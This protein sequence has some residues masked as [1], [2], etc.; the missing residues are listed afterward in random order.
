MQGRTSIAIA[1]RLSTI[2]SCDQIFVIDQG[3]II[4]KGNHDKLLAKKGF[5]YDL[6][7]T[8]FQDSL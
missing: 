3:K 5:Y 7:T 8:Q 1:H 6:Y 2:T 4:E